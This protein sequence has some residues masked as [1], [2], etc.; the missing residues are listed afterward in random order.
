[1]RRDHETMQNLVGVVSRWI[2]I[3]V[4]SERGGNASRVA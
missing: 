4:S 1:M 3:S 2:M